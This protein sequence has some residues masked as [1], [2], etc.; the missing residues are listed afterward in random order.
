MVD[1]DVERVLADIRAQVIGESSG[2]VKATTQGNGSAAAPER[3]V[4]DRPSRGNGYASLTVLARAWDR[5][6]PLVSNRT[7]ASAGLELW[8]KAKIK[9]ALRWITWEQVNFNAATHHTL[10]EVIETLTS[11]E[12]RLANLQSQFNAE[13]NTTREQLELQREELKTQRAELLAEIRTR[14]DQI[15]RE[16]AI[17]NQR[18]SA[19]LAEAEVLQKMVNEF[20]SRLSQLDH[21]QQLEELVNEFRERDERLLDE[22][23]VCFKQLSLELTE[24]QVLQ[25]SARREL[26][27][28]IAKLEK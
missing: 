8:I 16:Q 22:Q 18:Q 27:T 4:S 6:P 24:S 14:K 9:R 5:L 3:L 7:G 17:L 12:Q 10:I 28:R 21:P 23:R 19:V 20:E 1:Q 13:A 25:D 2:E 11:C 26:E 15:E